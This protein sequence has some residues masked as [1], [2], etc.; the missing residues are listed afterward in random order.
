MMPLKLIG[1]SGRHRTMVASKKA[2]QAKV[3]LLPSPDREWIETQLRACASTLGLKVFNVLEPGSMLGE[4]RLG[5]AADGVFDT[6]RS[7]PLFLISPDLA[8]LVDLA[9]VS[10][11]QHA[12]QVAKDA[13][14]LFVYAHEVGTLVFTPDGVWK[15]P[16]DLLSWLHIP[17][18]AKSNSGIL[19]SRPVLEG[20]AAI[21]ATALE[22]YAAGSEIGGAADWGVDLF[23]LDEGS[24]FS[25]RVDGAIDLTG[26]P[27]K[28]VQGPFIFLAPGTWEI[29]VRFSVDA[30]AANFHYRFEW[31]QPGVFS[32]FET[33]IGR[34]G[35]YE[36]VLSRRW[37]WGAAAEFLV[38]LL[39]S[40]MGGKFV[41]MGASITRTE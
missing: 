16:I 11:R 37:E 33:P 5:I 13:S 31:G 38:E 21:V 25:R 26:P 14:E 2:P 40:S 23:M 35:V 4:H 8:T 24:N 34:A 30:A 18:P 22:V 27:R 12:M 29:R 7:C 32:T 1:G 39:E 17:P 6:K 20:A 10:G 36:V 9:G 15:E 41:F 19:D 3:I 28:L